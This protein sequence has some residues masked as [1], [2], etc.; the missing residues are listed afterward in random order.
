M[1]Q[2]NT[3]NLKLSNSQLN[4]SKSGIKYGTEVTFE[5]SLNVVGDSNDENIF[6]HKLLL[7][8]THV[9]RLRKAFSNGPLANIKL[10]KIQSHKIGQSRRFL[11]RYL[12]PL[13]KTGLPLIGNEPK[14]LARDVLI[15]LHQQH[16]QQM[17]LFIRKCLDQVC[18][19]QT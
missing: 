5:T 15:P 7:T 4:K 19:L 14:L 11:D 13:P 8:N 17:Q 16:Q 2:C 3:L 9:S 6:P 10:S 18:V 1:T 12:G